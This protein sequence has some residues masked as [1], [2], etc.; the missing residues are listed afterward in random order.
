MNAS[1]ITYGI[2]FVGTFL[3]IGAGLFLFLA[4][5]SLWKR[6]NPDVDNPGDPP[7]WYMRSLNLWAGFFVL[8]GAVGGFYLISSLIARLS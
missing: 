1:V 6:F 4:K 2:G 8:V 7:A 5:W 3:L